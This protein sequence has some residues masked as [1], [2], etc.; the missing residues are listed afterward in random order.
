VIAWRLL[1]SSLFHEEDKS[2][3]K[4]DLQTHSLELDFGVAESGRRDLQCWRFR[5]SYEQAN[6]DQELDVDCLLMEKNKL[7]KL[8]ID[9]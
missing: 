4:K 6:K 8:G 3:K 2:K 7:L 9:C 1:F 5:I